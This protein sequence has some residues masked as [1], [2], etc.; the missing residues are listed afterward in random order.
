[1]TGR[2]EPEVVLNPRL[3]RPDLVQPGCDAAQ[4]N[5]EAR[6]WFLNRLSCCAVCAARK[7]EAVLSA[8]TR[9]RDKRPVSREQLALHP[10]HRLIAHV[11][12]GEAERSAL[13]GSRVTRITGARIA[14][15]APVLKEAFAYPADGDNK[16][17]AR[18][19]W[20]FP[21]SWDAA[22][23]ERRVRRTV[24]LPPPAVTMSRGSSLSMRRC[25]ARRRPRQQHF[26]YMAWR[27]RTT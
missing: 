18:R 1:M 17:D 22:S 10:M 4:E 23:S 16:W 13:P 11:V 5:V 15:C 19:R 24:A 25:A 3:V 27:S 6:S 21:S 9:Q 7:K 26:L 12:T 2:G 8:G 14:G 20:K